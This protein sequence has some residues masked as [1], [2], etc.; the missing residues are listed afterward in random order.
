MSKK[1]HRPKAQP[2]VISHLLNAFNLSYRAIRANKTALDILGDKIDDL[3][4]LLHERSYRKQPTLF[5]MDE[6]HTWGNPEKEILPGGL[7]WLVVDVWESDSIIPVIA[8][9]V[10]GNAVVYEPLY[11]D[12]ELWANPAPKEIFFQTKGQAFKFIAD[13]ADGK[14]TDV[15]NFHKETPGTTHSSAE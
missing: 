6:L 4:A 3:A 12:P 14:P 5:I 10:H 2:E 15:P 13:R 9:E 1:E 8:K 11:V 7:Y